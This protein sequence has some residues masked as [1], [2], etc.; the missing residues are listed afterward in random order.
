MP[1]VRILLAAPLAFALALAAPAR[2]EERTVPQ[3]RTEM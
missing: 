3:S 2:A 1:N